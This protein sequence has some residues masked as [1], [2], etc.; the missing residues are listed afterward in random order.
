MPLVLI[1]C[2]KYSAAVEVGKI[3]AESGDL[4]SAARLRNCGN[5]E[6]EHSDNSK[7]QY[8]D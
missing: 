5:V 2:K 1:L 6:R 7:R 4:H 8:R 3:R